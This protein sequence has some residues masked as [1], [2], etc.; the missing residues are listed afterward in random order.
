[1]AWCP[2]QFQQHIPG[3]DH[4]VH[5]VRDRVFA[6]EIRS[7]S[8]DFAYED[9]RYAPRAGVE[10]T[11]RASTLPGDIADLCRTLTADLGLSLSGIDLRLTPTGEWYCFEVNPSPAFTYYQEGT[12]QPIAEA[13]AALL[14]KTRTNRTVRIPY[15]ML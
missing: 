5:V 13:I 10:I 7:A 8:G 3:V 6:S 4:R 15:E 2:T 11:I 9:Y 12:G 14:I 1:V